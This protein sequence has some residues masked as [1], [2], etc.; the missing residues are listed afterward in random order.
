[1][2]SLV[3]G[4]VQVVVRDFGM[5]MLVEIFARMLDLGFKLRGF[6]DFYSESNVV[7]VV[8]LVFIAE[9]VI[10]IFKAGY[11]NGRRNRRSK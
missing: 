2:K 4:M 10:A 1:M 8:K 7:G 5:T 11:R 6:N 3:K 9:V